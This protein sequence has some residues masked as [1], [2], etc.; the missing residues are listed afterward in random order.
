MK[1]YMDRLRELENAEPVY[2]VCGDLCSV[3]PRYTARTEEELHQT[4][5]FWRQAGWRATVVSN[6]DIRCGGCGSRKTCSFMLLPCLR[7]HG[8]SACRD[9][10]AFPCERIGDMLRRSEEKIAQCRAACACEA[11]FAMLCRA[12]YEKEKNLAEQPC[13]MT[14]RIAEGENDPA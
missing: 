11:E 14:G 7:E 13:C 1:W 4:A 2:S 8:V 9:C 12:F 5:V 6:E 10:A 3:C